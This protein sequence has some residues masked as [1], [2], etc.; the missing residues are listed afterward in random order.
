MNRKENRERL[1]KLQ[2]LPKVKTTWNEIEEFINDISKYSKK[3]VGVYGV[4]RAGELLA[5][6][7]SYKN[8]I[9]ILNAPCKGCLVIDDDIG[10]GLTAS[11]YI[12]KYDVAVMFSNRSCKIIPEFVWKYY[13][14]ENI[15]R[16]FPWEE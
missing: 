13:D 12:G 1:E 3:Y 11:A 2:E 9:P 16:R 4:P 6:L 15:F 5:I 8:D 7:Y 14:D 10:T